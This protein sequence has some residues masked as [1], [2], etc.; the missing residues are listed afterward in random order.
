MHNMGLC[1]MSITFLNYM[2]VDRC[3]SINVKRI[4]ND[5]LLDYQYVK[6]ESEVCLLSIDCRFL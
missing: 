5:D 6:I 2:D 3:F 4:F 1:T